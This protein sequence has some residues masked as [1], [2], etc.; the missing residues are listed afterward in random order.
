MG[1]HHLD[2]ANPMHRFIAE[3]QTYHAPPC[4]S[5]QEPRGRL[6]VLALLANREI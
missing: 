1:R 2:P 3:H 4:H 6:G 5:Q